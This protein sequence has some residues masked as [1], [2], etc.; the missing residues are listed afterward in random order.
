RNFP[1]GFSAVCVIF[2]L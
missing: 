1:K 2:T